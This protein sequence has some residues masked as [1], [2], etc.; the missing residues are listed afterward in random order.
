M[1][2][3]G[4]PWGKEGL[5]GSEGGIEGRIEGGQHRESGEGSRGRRRGR[6]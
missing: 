4:V 1:Y 3:V 6:F 2:G 5:G